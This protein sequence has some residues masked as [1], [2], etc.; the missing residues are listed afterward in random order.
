MDAK[1]KSNG[2]R[3]AM[4][5]SINN[6]ASSISHFNLNKS[7]TSLT[8]SIEKLSSG[9]RINHAADDAAGMYIGDQ[10]NSQALGLGQAMRNANDGLS[11]MQIVDSSLEESINIMNS[12][13]TK[14]IQAAQDSQTTTTRRTIQEDINKLLQE[15]DAIAATTSFNNQKLLSGSFTDKKFQVGAYS[16]ETI[17]VSFDSAQT[18]KIGHVRTADI[19]LTNSTGGSVS[20]TFNSSLSNETLKI[21]AIEVLYDNTSAHSMAA[22]AGAINKYSDVT[23]ISGQ[24][25]V[26]STSTDPVQAGSTGADFTINDIAIGTVTTLAN[27]SNSALVSAINNKNSSHGVTASLTSAG[28]LKLTSDDGRAIKVAGAGTSLLAAD[29]AAMST[30][31]FVQIQQQG[32]YAIDMT[33][34]GA[35][36][37]VSFTNNLTF[38]GAMTTT[39]DST[40]ASGSILSIGSFLESGWSA[41][42]VVT[43]PDLT[44][45]VVTV[46]DSTLKSGSVL[47]AAS[48]IQKNSVL[49]GIAFNNAALTTTADS[50]LK[51]G[52]TLTSGSI[53]EAGTYL[54]NDI[55]VGGLPVAAGTTLS[56]NST[57]SADAII[58]NDMLI[59][60]GSTVNT[61]SEIAASSYIGANLTL[62]SAMTIN[63]D[64][65][66]KANST[67]SNGAAT[68]IAAGSTIGGDATLAAGLT[69]TR[70]MTLKNG[71]TLAAASELSTGSTLG[72]DVTLNGDHTTT[73]D[74]SLAAGS[75][76]ATGSILAAGTELVNSI[77]AGVYSAGDTVTPDYTTTGPN[78]LN[79]AQT[80]KNGSV[81]A[82]SSILGANSGGAASVA[83][84]NETAARLADINVLT[85]EGAQTAISIADAALNDLD[86]IRSSAGATQNQF[87]SSIN[88]LSVSKMNILN[89]RSRIMDVD[90]S[91]ETLNF[92]RLN[93][94]TQTGSYAL[95][96]ANAT[97]SRVMDLLQGGGK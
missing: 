67:I 56:A 90:F 33:D 23:G 73:A 31:G 91:D 70:S 18:S 74:L 25:V 27:D 80:L 9:L 97:L 75:F 13:K 78:T 4:T 44:G 32:S 79:F 7:I 52:S 12:I 22:L 68:S 69:T 89:A 84:N 26:S 86:K 54:T 66:L 45:N 72:G 76:L 11:I 57:L 15:L 88:N 59:L 24:A 40:L 55:E 81:L 38:V 71:S 46:S 77:D 3:P 82:S 53:L 1:N 10:L 8:D 30:F 60:S 92:T 42:T 35:G 95:T 64:M 16:G 65:T 37:S 49:G 63:Q 5:L 17:P 19:A 39:M 34:T 83:L 36:L 93:V 62:N 20:L 43:G 85:Q 41:G 29:A 96:Q 51:A 14:A 58:G 2:R 94:L 28:Q 50:L 61:A 87:S 47:A 6:Y 21:Q 48:V